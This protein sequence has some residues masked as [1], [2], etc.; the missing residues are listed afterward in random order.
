MLYMCVNKEML[1]NAFYKVTDVFTNSNDF[2]RYSN[3]VRPVLN[4][5]KE[6]RRSNWHQMEALS[7]A[8]SQLK[9]EIMKSM[10]LGQTQRASN[11]K[12]RV[13]DVQER[14]ASYIKADEDVAGLSHWIIEFG[15]QFELHQNTKKANQCIAAAGCTLN[16]QELIDNISNMQTMSTKMSDVN[17]IARGAM[18]DQRVKR[19]TS[20]DSLAI[21]R[22][23]SRRERLIA[24][25]AEMGESNRLVAEK[26]EVDLISSLPVVVVQ[27]ENRF[28]PNPQQQQQGEW[29]NLDFSP[30]K[31]FANSS[32]SGDPEL[33]YEVAMQARL[34]NL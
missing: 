3:R 21:D 10:E 22:E 31:S 28:W 23:M 17:T 33:D 19:S 8:E 29:P 5:L 26:K 4:R 15:R 18:Q 13:L 32:H 6:Q 14:Y 20:N 34:R 16:I 7:L 12:Y 9:K 27:Q 25:D 30:Q 11:L 1:T 2:I 24:L